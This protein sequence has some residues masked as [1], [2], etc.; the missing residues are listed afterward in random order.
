MTW[1]A[2]ERALERYGFDISPSE[3]AAMAEAIGRGESV[4]LERRPDGAETHLCIVPSLGRVMQAVYLPAAGRIVTV[5]H[6]DSRRTR[7]AK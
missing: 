3:M 6:H 5:I 4:L 7:G 2:V 1:H